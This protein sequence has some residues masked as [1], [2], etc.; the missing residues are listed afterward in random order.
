MNDVG[1]ASPV[2]STSA[3]GHAESTDGL[4]NVPYSKVCLAQSCK[5]SKCP[6]IPPQLCANLIQDRKENL[7][8]DRDVYRHRIGQNMNVGVH[9]PRKIGSRHQQRSNREPG[10][11]IIPRGGRSVRLYSLRQR[12]CR[13]HKS[14]GGSLRRGKQLPTRRILK[15]TGRREKD[16]G[17]F[18]GYG[19]EN[20]HVRLSWGR[21]AAGSHEIEGTSRL[22]YRK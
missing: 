3:V 11:N 20:H 13:A 10:T 9:H 7:K 1:V 5:A 18:Q 8:A 17:E 16:K 12:K 15:D 22:G 6:S 19:G 4:E 2:N 14:L 21:Q